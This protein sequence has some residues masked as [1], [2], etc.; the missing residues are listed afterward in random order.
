MVRNAPK[1][2]GEGSMTENAKIINRL[3]GE[4][5]MWQEVVLVPE[6]AQDRMMVFDRID[7]IKEQLRYYKEIEAWAEREIY[8]M[9]LD[10]QDIP[11][12]S[13]RRQYEGD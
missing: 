10:G 12:Y 4:M 5:K 11:D 9:K 8:R 3:Q 2:K 7:T 1:T 6:R 13:H